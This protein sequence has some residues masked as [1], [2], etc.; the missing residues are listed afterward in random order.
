MSLQEY[1]ELQKNQLEG[2][3]ISLVSEADLH[4][5]Q[6]LMEGPKGSA[7]E[8]R[9][10]LL[11]SLLARRMEIADLQSLFKADDHA[12]RHLH[13]C[14]FPADRLSFQTTHSQLQDQNLPP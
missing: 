11:Q 3:K 12:G 1:S 5:W 4:Q 7:Y 14:P 13:P 10:L 2:I 8:V 9:E 6:I